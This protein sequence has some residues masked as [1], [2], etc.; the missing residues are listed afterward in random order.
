MVYSFFSTYLQERHNLQAHDGR[1]LW[2]YDLSTSDYQKLKEHLCNISG[3]IDSRDVA[4]FFA[5]WW[6]KE[7]TEGIP[8]KEMVLNTLPSCRIDH[9][10][11][12]KL[13]KKGAERLG[14]K[15]LKRKNSLYFRT[16][17]MQGGLPVEHIGKNTGVYTRFLKKVIELEPEGIEDIEHNSE[18]IKYLPASSR[19]EAIYGS[20]LEIAKA[21]SRGD[22]HFSDITFQN[23]RSTSLNSMFKELKEHKNNLRKQPQTYRT[24]KASWILESKDGQGT[25]QLSLSF[26]SQ[27]KRDNLADMLCILPEDL[28]QSYQL[29]INDGVACVIRRTISGDYKVLRQDDWAYCWQGEASIPVAYLL[30]EQKR[31]SF[32]II[33]PN[34]I[35]IS[36]PSLWTEL[37]DMTWKLHKGRNCAEESAYI[38][39]ASDWQASNENTGGSQVIELLNEKISLTAFERSITFCKEEQ[40]RTFNTGKKGF[41]WRVTNATHP[42]WLTKSNITVIAG[43]PEMWVYK[44]GEHVR[45]P[46]IKYRKRGQLQWLDMGSVL[47]SGYIELQISVDDIT[48]N[49]CVYNIGK[50]SLDYIDAEQTTAKINAIGDDFNFTIK[51][52]VD[53]HII[54][55]SNNC[56]LSVDDV[57]KIPETLKCSLRTNDQTALLHFEIAS[58]F[59]G[60][61]ILDANGTLCDSNKAILAVKYGGFR[62]YSSQRNEDV[63][64]HF[65]NSERLDI[66]IIKPINQQFT[67]L[68]IF[69]DIIKRLLALKNTMNWHNTVHIQ[70]K[71]AKD[72]LLA[73][74]KVKAYNCMFNKDE[75]KVK[76]ANTSDTVNIYGIP[77]DCSHANLEPVLFDKFPDGYTLPKELSSFMNKFVLV[78]EDISGNDV[79]MPAF[80]RREKNLSLDFKTCNVEDL[81]QLK[82]ELPSGLSPREEREERINNYVDELKSSLAEDDIWKSVIKYKD[83]C[84]RF[85]VPFSSIDQLTAATCTPGVLA[86]F[87]CLLSFYSEDA[88]NLVNELAPDIENTFGFCFHW[89]GAENWQNAITW[90]IESYSEMY[91]DNINEIIQSITQNIIELLTAN[92]PHEQYEIIKN[93]VFGQR[94]CQ[95]FSH[96]NTTIYD[97]R[98]ELGEKILRMLPKL[99][100]IIHKEHR[101]L[102]TFKQEWKPVALLINAPLAVALSI[103]GR[104]K[105]IWNYKKA[106]GDEVRRNIQYVSWLNP[107]WYSSAIVH[108]IAKTYVSEPV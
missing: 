59:V 22:E 11:L 46:I 74:Y 9:K 82:L 3:V 75:G 25:I 84:E 92:Y 96:L 36:R 87:F 27:I 73:D 29:V 41:E 39:A 55:E 4:L 81:Q 5:E 17:L 60:V 23:H 69:D 108:F 98:S 14:I 94:S 19:N 43:R 6:R 26:P 64:I 18:L 10:A 30:G 79:Y 58:P 24:F 101:D 100:P 65:F 72:E 45:K 95:Q 68:R 99:S 63:N 86:K 28:K 53:V 102:M 49:D 88:D 33:L 35:D 40:C 31:F 1:K 97:L 47:P 21:I 71:N 13:A 50:F 78:A 89:I 105:R 20:C 57:N 103:T 77:V 16:L 8:S 37:D 32:P 76:L 61:G 104:D 70:L 83:I 44:D 56:F 48:E 106:K 15:W 67:P 12:Y 93:H 107:V 52:H 51:P 54:S 34:A 90:L 42:N 62:L 66:C 7:Y 80:Y 38:L 91:S 85:N 2:Q